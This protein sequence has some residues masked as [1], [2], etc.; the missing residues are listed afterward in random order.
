[1]KEEETEFIEIIGELAKVIEMMKFLLQSEKF[2]SLPK[3]REA[4]ERILKDFEKFKKALLEERELMMEHI[5]GG[6]TY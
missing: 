6:E 4:L 5:K 3:T 1:M 2:S